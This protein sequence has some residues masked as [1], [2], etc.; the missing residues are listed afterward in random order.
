MYLI[1]NMYNISPIR[2][3]FKTKLVNQKKLKNKNNKNAKEKEIFKW[4]MILK[5]EVTL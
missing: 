1:Y 2:Y 4:I 5:Y 3:I